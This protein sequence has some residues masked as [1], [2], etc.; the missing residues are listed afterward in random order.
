MPCKSDYRVQ[1]L[2]CAEEVVILRRE[3]GALPGV[4]NL[5]F[6][7]VNA[8][9]SVEYDAEAVPPERIVAA[10]DATGMKALPWEIRGVAPSGSFWVQ[11]GRLVLAVLGGVLLVA[12]FV[13]HWMLQLNRLNRFNRLS[14]FYR[15]LT[16][17]RQGSRRRPPTLP[18]STRSPRPPGS[19]DRRGRR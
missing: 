12:G 11:H 8:R 16:C 18:H 14:R 13:T 17:S 2:D 3:V 7:V 4:I 6:D 10:V 1:G 15:S 5:E 9:M 19:R